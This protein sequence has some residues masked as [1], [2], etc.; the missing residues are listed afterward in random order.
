MLLVPAIQKCDIIKFNI[1][2]KKYTYNYT[3]LC[4]YFEQSDKQ[5]F[6]FTTFD[7]IDFLDICVLSPYA[8]G[9]EFV[10]KSDNDYLDG[11]IKEKYKFINLH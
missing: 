5:S 6:K 2:L 11:I 8:N 7:D 4:I 3:L 10:Y 1:N 9:V